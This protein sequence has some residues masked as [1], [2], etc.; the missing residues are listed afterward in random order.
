MAAI[1]VP[2]VLVLAWPDQKPAHPPAA[3]ASPS[4]GAQASAPATVSTSPLPGVTPAG[5]AVP[6]PTAAPRSPRPT[7]SPSSSPS[8]APGQ[9]TALKALVRDLEA[10]GQLA[11]SSADDLDHMLD[12]LNHQV[13]EGKLPEARDKLAA[14]RNKNDDLLAAG[15]ISLVGY[16]A[17]EEALHQLALALSVLPTA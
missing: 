8:S 11:P 14:I 5:F 13:V 6:S 7:P 17:V 9:I 3:A 16:A 12:D 15:K 1:A 4:F 10:T 2:A